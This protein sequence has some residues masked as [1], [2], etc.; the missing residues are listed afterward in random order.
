[1]L[2]RKKL[3]VTLVRLKEYMCKF[4]N[5][6]NTKCFRAVIIRHSAVPKVLIYSYPAI[7]KILI[8]EFPKLFV[9]IATV[10]RTYTQKIYVNVN[11]LSRDDD[12]NK[13]KH[14]QAEMNRLHKI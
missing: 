4:I 12:R 3:F 14:Y 11:S 8:C 2:F 9:A 6:L 1:M 10:S 5:R 7:G 13:N